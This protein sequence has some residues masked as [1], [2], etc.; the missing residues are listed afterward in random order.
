MCRETRLLVNIISVRETPSYARAAIRY[1]QEKWANERNMLVYE[2]CILS[3]LD[4]ECFLPQ[5]YLLYDGDRTI[6]CAGLITNDFISRMD[7][8]PWL[9]A[10]FIEDDMRGQ[11]L[12][13]LLIERIKRDARSA[14]YKHL[15][16][17]TDHVG[18]YERY[19]FEYLAQGY[20]PW[21]ESSRIYKA[22]LS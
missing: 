7:L 15:Y 3:C 4:A 20:H 11:S 1:F 22:N 2:D 12:G 6:G 9:C 16:L 8:G 14:G 21:G 19:G 18:Y 10:L 5:W 13:S 17:C